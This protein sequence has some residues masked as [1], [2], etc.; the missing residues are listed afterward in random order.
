MMMGFD[1]EQMTCQVLLYAGTKT[2]QIFGVFFRGR[3]PL[4]A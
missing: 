2:G 1:A 3:V 4:Q